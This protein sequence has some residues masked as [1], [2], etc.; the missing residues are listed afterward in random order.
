[1]AEQAYPLSEDYRYFKYCPEEWDLREG[2]GPFREI[3]AY[4]RGHKEENRRLFT[5]PETFAF[6]AAFEEHC[7]KVTEACKGRR[8]ALRGGLRGIF[9]IC[10][11]IFAPTGT[12]VPGSARSFSPV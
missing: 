5:D 12:Q 7:R 9:P 3:S 10:F 6:T 8:S 2:G 1:M 4:M 11:W